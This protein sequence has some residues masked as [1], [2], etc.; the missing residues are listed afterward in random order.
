[1]PAEFITCAGGEVDRVCCRL[2]DRELLAAAEE[3]S[4]S[5][6]RGWLVRLYQ[7]TITVVSREP[8]VGIPLAEGTGGLALVVAFTV[9][10]SAPPSPSGTI[11]GDVITCIL[12]VFAAPD[13]RL[14]FTS[15]KDAMPLE[16]RAKGMEIAPGNGAID[17]A[18]M[19]LGRL[20]LSS[21]R[22]PLLEV[23]QTLPSDSKLKWPETSIRTAY[24]MTTPVAELITPI[25]VASVNQSS[26]F[27]AVPRLEAVS[28][29]ERRK[30][31]MKPGAEIRTI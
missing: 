18:G 2:A 9:E 23:N 17:A 26:P 27:G 7:N 16:S 21:R 31:L 12:T 19:C 25:P 20:F 14:K 28:P 30:D 3:V 29:G 24:S 13:K 5:E 1:M 8:S 6:G 22:T 15:A 4:L 10:T 11:L